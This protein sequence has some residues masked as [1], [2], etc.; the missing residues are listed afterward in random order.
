MKFACKDEAKSNKDITQSEKKVMKEKKPNEILC[1][2]NI[3]VFVSFVSFHCSFYV[4]EKNLLLGF[5]CFLALH[6]EYPYSKF[7][8]SDENVENERT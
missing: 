1:K 6:I 3:Q 5:Y 7:R 2:E 4:D 8:T